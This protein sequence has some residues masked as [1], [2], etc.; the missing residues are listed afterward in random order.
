MRNL[1]KGTQLLR[2]SRREITQKKKIQEGFEPRTLNVEVR[3]ERPQVIP[4]SLNL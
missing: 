4:R 1:I 3:P 2:G